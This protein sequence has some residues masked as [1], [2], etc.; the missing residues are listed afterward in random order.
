[1]GNAYKIHIGCKITLVVN[2]ISMLN[3]S[4]SIMQINV[5]KVIVFFKSKERAFLPVVFYMVRLKADFKY[6]RF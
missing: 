4:S 5:S 2:K 3:N 6:A 1:M